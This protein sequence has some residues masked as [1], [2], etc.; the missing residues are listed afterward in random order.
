MAETPNNNPIPPSDPTPGNT[1]EQIP[2]QAPYQQYA[3]YPEQK[4]GFSIAALV[5]GIISI[6][7][8]CCC[9]GVF[10]AP[11]A[12]IFG[13]VA[14]AKKQGGKGMAITGIVL[15]GLTL[16]MVIATAVSM[17]PLLKN[18]DQI[19]Q[20][21]VQVLEDQDEVFPAYEADQTLPDCLNKYKEPPYSDIL[22]QYDIT[23]YDIMDSLLSQYKTGQLPRPDA[24]VTVSA[25]G[26]PALVYLVPAG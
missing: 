22:E 25:A 3:P 21:L 6:V 18:M 19:S 14:L 24:G 20:D 12:L 16:L 13:I 1:Y 11:F 17:A 10:T 9:I 23:I 15:G 26:A 5:L 8:L 7:G 4:K 2:P